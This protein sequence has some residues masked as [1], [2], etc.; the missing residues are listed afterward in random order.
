[1]YY[2]TFVSGGVKHVPATKFAGRTDRRHLSYRSSPCLFYRWW[3]LL[4][5]HF[6][7]DPGILLAIRVYHHIQSQRLIRWLVW[8]SLVIDPCPVFPH[9]LMALV[10][11]RGWGIRHSGSTGKAD[12]GRHSWHGDTGRSID[13]KSA[14]TANVPATTADL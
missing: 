3:T 13:G 10:P 5:T 12:Y 8:L 14:A 7:C 11:G 6:I 1:M 4:S 9:W 2:C